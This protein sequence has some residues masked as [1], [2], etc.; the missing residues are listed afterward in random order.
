MTPRRLATALAAFLAAGPALA[1]AAAQEIV[2]TASRI[3][4]SDRSS[5]PH[6]T[7]LRR[8][9]HLVTQVQVVCDTRDPTQRA[10]ELRETLRALIAAAQGGDPIALSVGDEILVPFTDQIIEKAIVADESK[11]DTSY[12]FIVVKT[13]IYDADSYDNAVARIEA[14]LKDAPKAGRTEVLPS[15][16]WNLTIVEP[17]KSR[18]E[19]MRLIAEDALKTARAF[20]PAYGVRLDGLQNSIQWYQTGPLD[21]ALYIDYAL[22]TESLG[23]AGPL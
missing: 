5:N 4:Y 1:D 13:P 15:G 14:F 9:D 20:G 2:V 6:V 16:A 3:A 7:L 12:A 11:P 10:N 23:P 21:L 17:E 8:A 18:E 22:A 19:L